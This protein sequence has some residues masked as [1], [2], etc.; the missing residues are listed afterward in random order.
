MPE[1][2]TL[3]QAQKMMG[4]PYEEEVEPP[5]LGEFKPR[6]DP[7]IS[8][9]SPYSRAGLPEPGEDPVIQGAIDILRSE[10]FFDVQ[11]AEPEPDVDFSISRIGK[12]AVRGAGKGIADIATGF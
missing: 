1:Y 7:S 9:E 6:P 10:G 8:K 5:E 11:E 12:Q 2:I 4:L 3:R